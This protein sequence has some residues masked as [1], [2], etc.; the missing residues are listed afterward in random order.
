VT[1]VCVEELSPAR[2]RL[3][4]ARRASWRCHASD[5]R[6]AEQQRR[7][8]TMRSEQKPKEQNRRSMRMWALGGMDDEPEG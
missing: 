8:A 7:E 5:S 6:Q 1:V 2:L 4:W 3:T